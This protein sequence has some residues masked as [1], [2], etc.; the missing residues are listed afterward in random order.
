MQN[1][2]ENHD[3][4]VGVDS[5]NIGNLSGDYVE[6]VKRL[7]RREKQEHQRS[8]HKNH[9]LLRENETLKSQ[10]LLRATGDGKH[11]NVPIKSGYHVVLQGKGAL[12]GA[13]ARLELVTSG[14]GDIKDQHLVY[15]YEHMA[16]TCLKLL[17]RSQN[18]DALQQISQDSHVHDSCTVLVHPSSST[19]APMSVQCVAFMGD[20]T[21]HEAIQRSQQIEILNTYAYDCLCVD[22]CTYCIH[23]YW[24]HN[25]VS[26]TYVLDTS[27][28]VRA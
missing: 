1:T 6:H 11:H 7:L 13:K 2:S 19:S 15:K 12:V 10:L 5:V 23:A 20:A 18:F 8:A 14:R 17:V 3:A 28:I 22:V 24:H 26:H 27:S 25:V 16:A 4:I 9:L 21:H